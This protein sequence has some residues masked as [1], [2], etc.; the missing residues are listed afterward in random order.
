MDE[1]GQKKVC[2]QNIWPVGCSFVMVRT[3]LESLKI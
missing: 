2:V 1:K 3:L